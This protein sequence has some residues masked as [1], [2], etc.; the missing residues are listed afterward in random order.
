MGVKITKAYSQ[1]GYDNLRISWYVVIQ[2]SGS[3]FFLFINLFLKIVSEW[4]FV[5]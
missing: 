4:A 2:G 3:I 1:L 5:K